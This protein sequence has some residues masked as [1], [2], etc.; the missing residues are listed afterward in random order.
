MTSDEPNAENNFLREWIH[1]I[2]GGLLAF[3]FLLALGAYLQGGNHALMRGLIVALCT[4]A[5]VTFW[6]TMLMARG[7]RGSAKFQVPGAKEMSKPD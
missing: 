6:W 1:W 5:F 3:G 2:M 7:N 4:A